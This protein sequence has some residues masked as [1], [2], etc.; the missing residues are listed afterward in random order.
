[1]YE[2]LMGFLDQSHYDIVLI[3]RPSSGTTAS[4]RLP[5]GSALAQAPLPRNMLVS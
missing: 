2:D 4:T 3:K 1:M 5:H